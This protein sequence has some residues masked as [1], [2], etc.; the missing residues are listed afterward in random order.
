MSFSRKFNISIWKWWRERG[1]I[2]YKQKDKQWQT[3]IYAIHAEIWKY[4]C[5]DLY[6]TSFSSVEKCLFNSNL[7]SCNADDI[8]DITKGT[9]DILR[10]KPGC[11]KS[12]FWVYCSA[13]EDYILFLLLSPWIA[14]WHDRCTISPNK[15]WVNM[16]W[17]WYVYLANVIQNMMC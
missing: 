6:K 5:P 8:M 2:K 1:M 12:G 14:W 9:V 13:Q 11:H 4:W 17:R 3:E 16:E 15:P 7:L 10:D